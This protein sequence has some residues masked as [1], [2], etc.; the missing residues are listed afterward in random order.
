VASDWYF[1]NARDRD[2][3]ARLP[4]GLREVWDWVIQD[5]L[6]DPYPDEF[7][8][9]TLPSPPFPDGVFHTWSGPFWLAYRTHNDEVIEI[10]AVRWTEESPLSGA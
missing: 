7:R 9:Q 5:I 3:V 1:A 4:P 2:F 10:L 8:R 6:D